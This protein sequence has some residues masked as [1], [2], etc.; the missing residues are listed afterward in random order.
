MIGKVAIAARRPW[1][2][3]AALTVAVGGALL[4]TPAVPLTH[5]DASEPAGPDDGAV[6]AEQL[7]VRAVLRVNEPAADR[8]AL[9]D[10]RARGGGMT[11]A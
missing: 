10:L 7:T 8:P 6:I 3:A 5:A 11:T 2:A 4:P 9:P 1:L